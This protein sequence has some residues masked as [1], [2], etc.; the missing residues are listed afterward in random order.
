MISFMQ[1]VI[2]TAMLNIT[3]PEQS[4]QLIKESKNIAYFDFLNAGNKAKDVY[5]NLTTN[6]Y[7]SNS[8]NHSYESSQGRRL[9]F[10]TE[11]Y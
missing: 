1:F 7:D 2:H 11:V 8:T 5:G 10:G 4:L 3:M 6:T 9:S